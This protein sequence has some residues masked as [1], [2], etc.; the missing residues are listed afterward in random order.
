[1]TSGKYT[2]LQTVVN[3]RFAL[4]SESVRSFNDIGYDNRNGNSR[5]RVDN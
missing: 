4:V 5:E 3:K 1:M 2:Y